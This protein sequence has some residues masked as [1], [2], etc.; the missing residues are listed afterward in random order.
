MRRALAKVGDSLNNINQDSGPV[1]LLKTFAM[2]F[3]RNKKISVAKSRELPVLIIIADF[4]IYAR[5]KIRLPA[6][7]YFFP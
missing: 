4:F 7:A 5:K 3:L 1:F 6:D 2:Y